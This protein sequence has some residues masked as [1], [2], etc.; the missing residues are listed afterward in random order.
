V[1]EDLWIWATGNV[2]L[3][4]LPVL[5]TYAALFVTGKRITVVSVLGDGVLFFFATMLSATLLMDVWRDRIA[6]QHRLETWVATL[7]FIV[8][9]LATV[10]TVG[11]FFITAMARFKAEQDG[12]ETQLA[13]MARFSWRVTA[14][15]A[16]L[17]LAVRAF[18]GI[19]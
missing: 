4:L 8:A 15:V 14:G 9:L 5:A 13:W 10:F 11:A 7:F 3:P 19:Y 16:I 12:D 2:V 17:C 1:S 18:A 6:Q